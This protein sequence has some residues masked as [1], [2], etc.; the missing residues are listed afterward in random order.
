M[1]VNGTSGQPQRRVRLA[2]VVTR[3]IVGGAQRVVW[4]LFEH[5]PRDQYEV[6]IVAGPEGLPRDAKDLIP[7]GADGEAET[8]HRL[9]MVRWLRRAIS[10]GHDLLAVWELA[11]LLR[12]LRIELVHTRTAK[13]GVIGGL[14]ARLAHVRAV[15]H[16]PAGHIYDPQ[17][18]IQGVSSHP[19]LRSGLLLVE[20]WM[21][22]WTTVLTALS[23]AEARETVEL[24]LASPEQI[25]CVPNGVEVEVFARKP[26]AER[27]RRLRRELELPARA[28]VVISVGRLSPVKGHRVL[29]E[30][31][32]MLARSPKSYDRPTGWA[33]E[34]AVR[35]VH[36]LLVGEGPER[37]ALE[38]LVRRLGVSEKV[39]FAGRR[40]PKEVAALLHLA[41]VFVLPSY[42]E[43]F[44]VVLLEAQAAGLPVVAT[45]VGGVG[46]VLDGGRTGL[47]VPPGEPEALGQAVSLVLRDG[48]L[49]GRLAREG[50]ERVTREFPVER[51]VERYQA[52]YRR[53]LELVRERR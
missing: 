24:G 48:A 40:E 28:K 37:A 33:G 49:A 5:L 36:L 8:R 32:A 21:G 23:Q 1:V 2:L 31:V 16:T 30:A 19:W 46:E 26:P 51:M 11:Q 12:R 39:H 29:V 50:R 53:A 38:A 9:H 47:L 22:R 20:R 4:S 17:A 3:L 27:L 34:E 35:G 25:V 42:Y 15:V 6:V 18:R 43:G 44:G 13:A 10:P 41:D 45:D 7:P 52:V 14:A